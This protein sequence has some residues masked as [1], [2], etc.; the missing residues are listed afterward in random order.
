MNIYQRRSWW[1]GVLRFK[2]QLL[3]SEKKKKSVFWTLI[4]AKAE[5]TV[6]VGL[7]VD[8]V[9]EALSCC[10]SSIYSAVVM[11]EVQNVLSSFIYLALEKNSRSSS[12]WIRRCQHMYLKKKKFPNP[13][14][15]QVEASSNFSCWKFR[16]CLRWWPYMGFQHSLRMYDHHLRHFL[17]SQ[18]NSHSLKVLSLTWSSFYLHAFKTQFKKAQLNFQKILLDTSGQ[19]AT[20]LHIRQRRYTM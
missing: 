15:C 1:I 6:Q 3:G 16:K 8:L 5:L 19:L 12:Y 18:N 9:L 11:K 13:E 2:I 20:K 4:K 14:S 17:W 10:I 7:G